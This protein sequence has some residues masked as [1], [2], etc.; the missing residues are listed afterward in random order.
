MNVTGENVSWARPFSVLVSQSFTSRSGAR[1]GSG[2][3]TTESTMV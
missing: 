3:S 2:R 1:Y